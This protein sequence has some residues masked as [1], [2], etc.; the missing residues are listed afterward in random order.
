MGDG[1]CRLGKEFILFD[2][3][4]SIWSSV[5]LQKSKYIVEFQLIMTNWKEATVQRL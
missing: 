1:K 3:I 5:F 4:S 2:Q